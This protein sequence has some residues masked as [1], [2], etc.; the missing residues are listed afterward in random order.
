MTK[1]IKTMQKLD[2]E[3]YKVPRKV[4]DLIPVKRIWPDG[5]FQTG[6]RYSMSF[7]FTDINYQVASKED[8]ERTIFALSIALEE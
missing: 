1:S 4:Q 5:I 7:G 8:K 6:T 3:K 2:K